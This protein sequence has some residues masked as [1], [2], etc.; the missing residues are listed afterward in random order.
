MSHGPVNGP[1]GPIEAFQESVIATAMKWEDD[2]G[3]V[4]T[5]DVI[6]EQN[7]EGAYIASTVAVSLE[8]FR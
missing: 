6:K 1:D 7:A 5:G 2:E 3:D 4:Q 8:S